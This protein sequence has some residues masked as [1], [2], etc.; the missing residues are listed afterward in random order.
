ME[1]SNFTINLAEVGDIAIDNLTIDA[2]TGDSSTH[3]VLYDN[4]TATTQTMTFPL[5][6]TD[7]NSTT[8]YVFSY[9]EIIKNLYGEINKET[10]DEKWDQ[11]PLWARKHLAQ[12]H[13]EVFRNSKYK[14]HALLRYRQEDFSGAPINLTVTSSA[15]VSFTHNS[16][17]I[18]ISGNNSIAVGTST[19]WTA[20]SSGTLS[21][22]A[23]VNPYT[24]ST[25]CT[26]GG[27]I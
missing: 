9:T 19:S 3:V 14:F 24:S 1:S 26:T 2:G 23:N 22:T 21:T 25:D 17:C 27:L 11:L 10:I 13:F 7:I 5:A 8:D 15:P 12:N 18:S 4:S 20:S 16:G 6:T